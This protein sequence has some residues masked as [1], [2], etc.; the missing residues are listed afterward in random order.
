MPRQISELIIRWHAGDPSALEELTPLIYEELR[1]LGRSHLRRHREATLLQ[2]TALVHEAWLRLSSKRDVPFHCRAEFFALASR[3]MRDILVDHVRRR[4]TAKRG[5]DQIEV[6][7]ESITVGD[8]PRVL[9]FLLLDNA[10][11]RLT[12][13]KPRC[14]QII[15]MRFFGG[16]S[17]PEVAEVLRVSSAT[18][19][20]EWNFARLWLVRELGP[21]PCDERATD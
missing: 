17:V 10:L 19:E 13:I 15:E 5:G 2:P 8:K 14:T 20:R 9:D 12:E 21:R 18:I 6:S 16:L 1:K 7:L 3:V 4:Q 11:T